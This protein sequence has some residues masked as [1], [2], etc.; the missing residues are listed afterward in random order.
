MKLWDRKCEKIRFLPN[1]W[2]WI[3]QSRVDCIIFNQIKILLAYYIRA[4]IKIL[5]EL[6][7]QNW[8]LI[9]LHKSLKVGL[10]CKFLS[11]V[12]IYLCKRNELRLAI[13]FKYQQIVSKWRL[14]LMH[15][16]R[17]V[18]NR[19]RDQ[20]LLLGF[21]GF[22]GLGGLG[23]LFLW[24]LSNKFF[25]NFFDSVPNWEFPIFPVILVTVLW[26]QKFPQNFRLCTTLDKS[27]L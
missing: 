11:N 10:N 2:E 23:A 3:T 12:E 13:S 5:F 1:F 22:S 19:G 18:Q 17:V 16:T 6:S 25:F 14:N 20:E 9:R 15:Y 21:G 8:N 27:N 26:H 7:S 4:W 24:I